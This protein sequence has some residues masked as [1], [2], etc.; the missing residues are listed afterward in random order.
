[1]T[2]KFTV[3]EYQPD[4]LTTQY[5][6]ADLE[7]GNALGGVGV[8]AAVVEQSPVQGH[9]PRAAAYGDEQNVDLI[10]AKVPF[11]AVQTQT[12]FARGR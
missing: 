5:G 12:Q 10:P 6:Y 8:A 9:M 3:P 4:A 1:M 7:Y 2:D 11:G